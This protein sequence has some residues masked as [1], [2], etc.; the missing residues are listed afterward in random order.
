MLGISHKKKE[1]NAQARRK[2]SRKLYLS[3]EEHRI[4]KKKR[5]KTEKIKRGEGGT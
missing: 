2:S 3:F 5:N 4:R 1:N